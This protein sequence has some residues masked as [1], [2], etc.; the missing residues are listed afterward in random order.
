MVERDR[1][2]TGGL[3]YQDCGQAGD[4]LF[5]ASSGLGC[6]AERELEFNPS[7]AAMAGRRLEKIYDRGS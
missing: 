7:R 5:R 6:E 2:K 1:R 3:E 4:S